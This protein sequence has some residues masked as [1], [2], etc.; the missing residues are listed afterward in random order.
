MVLWDHYNPLKLVDKSIVVQQNIYLFV[1]VSGFGVGLQL[2]QIPKLI[3][4]EYNNI[5]LKPPEPFPW[6]SFVMSR[7]IGIIPILWCALIFS[8]PMW[9]RTYEVE[10]STRDNIICTVL[11]VFCMQSWYRPQCAT[12]PNYVLFASIILNCFILY[13]LCRVVFCYVQRYLMKWSE[14]SLVSTSGL[15]Y[16]NDSN[17]E[18]VCVLVHKKER[19]WK[20]YIGNI[21]TLLRYS[22]ASLNLAVIYVGFCFILSSGLMLVIWKH[23]F[24]KNAFV[25][26]P[27]FIVGVF[28]SSCLCLL[29]QFIYRFVNILLSFC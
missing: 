26:F 22:K 3:L 9:T 2:R 6:K 4:N 12:G 13:T 25:F 28:G 18:A 16:D 11:Y 17:K 10:G 19:T 8:I 24:A 7:L 27:Y 29:H 5:T 1:L 23:N 14:E 15:F 21:V 20:M